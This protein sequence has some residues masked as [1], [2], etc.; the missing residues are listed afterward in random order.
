MIPLWPTEVLQLMTS[1]PAGVSLNV[2]SRLNDTAQLTESECAFTR[3]IASVRIHMER[4]IEV[5]YT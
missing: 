1:L 4:A 2:P 5:S 3:T